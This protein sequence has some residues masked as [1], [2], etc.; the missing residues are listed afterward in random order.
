M[1]ILSQ[2]PTQLNSLLARIAQQ[3][4]AALRAL[5]DATAGALLAVAHRVLN[6]RAAAEDVLQEVFVGVWRKAA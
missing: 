5:Y 2:H 6:D 4:R 1:S 3:D